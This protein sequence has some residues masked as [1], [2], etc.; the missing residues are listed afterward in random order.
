[1]ADS[2]FERSEDSQVDRLR[3]RPETSLDLHDF[4]RKQ[5]R[6]KARLPEDVQIDRCYKTVEYPNLEILYSAA[7]RAVASP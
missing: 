7:I 2:V 4:A 1:M 3:L 5:Q 6:P